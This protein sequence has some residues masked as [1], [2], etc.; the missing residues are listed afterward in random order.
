MHERYQHLADFLEYPTRPLS[1]RATLG[2]HRRASASTLNFPAGFLDDVAEH[3]RRTRL[4][5]PIAA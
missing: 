4:G 1:E 2:F 5:E 3:L